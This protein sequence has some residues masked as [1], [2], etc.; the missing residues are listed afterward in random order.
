MKR[1]WLARKAI[2]KKNPEDWRFYNSTNWRQTSKRF[3]AE[4]PLCVHCLADGFIVAAQ[5]VDHIVPLRFGG[6][7]LDVRNL[8]AL[9]FR[10]HAKK[11]A[12]ESKM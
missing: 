8:Q 9:C 12:K 10:C 6:E 1:P 4:N 3:L 2:R 5:C 7:K 11:S